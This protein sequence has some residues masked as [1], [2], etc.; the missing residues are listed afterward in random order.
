MVILTCSDILTSHTFT[1][2]HAWSSYSSRPSYI[3]EKSVEEHLQLA[4]DAIAVNG[5]KP[6]GRPWLSL[7]EAARTYQ[8]SKTTLTARF[9]GRKCKRE[10]HEHEK[11]LSCGEEAALVE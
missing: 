5:F 6:N 2:R 1:T 3:E 11:T 10:S 8:V 4:L 9:N 7:R